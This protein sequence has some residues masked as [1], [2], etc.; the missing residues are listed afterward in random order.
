[1]DEPNRLRP[2]TLQLL[3]SRP[4]DRSKSELPKCEK[5][6]T[7]I[8]NTEPKRVQPCIDTKRPRRPND[9]SGNELPE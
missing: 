1:M 8:E 9:R 3:P 7:D 6:S 4:N 2:A 5:S